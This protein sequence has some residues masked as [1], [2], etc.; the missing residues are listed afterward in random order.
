MMFVRHVRLNVLLVLDRV[1][2]VLL[3]RVTI[4]E[5]SIICVLVLLDTMMIISILIAF[6]VVTKK[7]QK[8]LNF[9]ENQ[10]SM[11]LY[12]I[13]NLILILISILILINLH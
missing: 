4:E 5:L 12:F 9:F 11:F 2:F 6:S 1:T 8:I 7:N 10:N 13:F 3:V